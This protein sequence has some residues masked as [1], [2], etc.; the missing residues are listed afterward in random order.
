MNNY[1][2][3]SICQ[4]YPG[5]NFVL[6][7]DHDDNL[8]SWGRNLVGELGLGFS[9]LKPDYE[10]GKAIVKFYKPTKIPGKF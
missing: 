2:K 7:K 8:Y 5:E 4:F 1:V 6:A 9:D 10:G 3:K